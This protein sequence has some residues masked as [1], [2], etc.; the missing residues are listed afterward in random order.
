MVQPCSKVF[1]C[2]DVFV[3]EASTLDD[4]SRLG[5]TSPSMVHEHPDEAHASP[6]LNHVSEARF[7]T[8][9]P[10]IDRI[11]V[12]TVAWSK[13]KFDPHAQDDLAQEIRAEAIE[14]G[15][16]DEPREKVPAYV[17]RL[18]VSRCVDAIRKRVRRHEMM[19]DVDP[20]SHIF[21]VATDADYDPVQEMIAIEQHEALRALLQE[22]GEPCTST[23]ID[24]YLRGMKYREIAENQGV[25]INTV[26][27]RLARC[28]ELLK[29]KV[30]NHPAF[31][32]AFNAG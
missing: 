17:R 22:L 18:A 25:N 7:E 6:H 5:F 24:C 26:A 19:P 3:S 32:K 30:K 10:E 28:M 29:K 8:L 16:F 31:V 12:D 14:K 9:Y 20:H 11:V 27:T 15:L 2:M 4:S 1:L 21:K 23:L 13:W